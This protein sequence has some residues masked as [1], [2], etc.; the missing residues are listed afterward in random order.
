MATVK[1]V[2]QPDGSILT[3]VNNQVQDSTKRSGDSN[4]NDYVKRAQKRSQSVEPSFQLKDRA[5]ADNSS[6][7]FT[8]SNMEALQI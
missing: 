5:Q 1:H 2:R 7:E 6:Y 4:F 3:V 8:H